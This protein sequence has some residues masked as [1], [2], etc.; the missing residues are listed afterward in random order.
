VAAARVVA[1]LKAVA[2]PPVAAEARPNGR[3][4][5]DGG[6]SVAL[7]PRHGGGACGG[8]HRRAAAT[9]TAASARALS[10]AARRGRL[11]VTVAPPCLAGTATAATD[12]DRGAAANPLGVL[13]MPLLVRL[14]GW[15]Q[16]GV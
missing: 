12:G 16:Q 14:R 4:A 10:G 13:L 9:S 3:A 11:P 1:A 6:V 15:K 7:L 8:L 2:S 5:R